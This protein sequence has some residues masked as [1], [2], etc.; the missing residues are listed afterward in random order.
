MFFYKYTN[1]RDNYQGIIFCYKYNLNCGSK[2]KYSIYRNKILV[3]L[4]DNKALVR[5][6]AKPY[7]VR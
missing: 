3:N 1:Y 6:Y 5:Y 2:N 4:D 7:F